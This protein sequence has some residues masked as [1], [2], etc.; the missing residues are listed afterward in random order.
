MPDDSPKDGSASHAS[1]PISATPPPVPSDART[2]V[3]AP[4]TD[5]LVG[6]VLL[7]RVRIIRPIAR[8]GM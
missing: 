8:G 7:D 3:A 5:P 2:P 6:K 4:V 1:D